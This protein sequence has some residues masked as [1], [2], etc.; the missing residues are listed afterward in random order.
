MEPNKVKFTEAESRAVVTRSGSRQAEIW[1]M[2]VKEYIFLVLR[3]MSSRD[4]TYSMVNIVNS[5][6]LYTENLQGK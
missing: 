5:S 3:Q 4:L 6:V 1:E 2:W